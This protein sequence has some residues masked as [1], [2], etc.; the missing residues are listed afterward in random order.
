MKVGR[1]QLAGGIKA[2]RRRTS[3]HPSASTE[4]FGMAKAEDHLSGAGCRAD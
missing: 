1:C 4:Q 3:K 2:A